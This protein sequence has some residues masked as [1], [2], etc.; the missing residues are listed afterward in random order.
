ML[1][2]IYDRLGDDLRRTTGHDMTLV[3]DPEVDGLVAVAI[4]GEALGGVSVPAKGDDGEAFLAELVDRLQEQF[5][6]RFVGGGWPTCPEHGTHPL[7]PVVVG[8]VAHWCCP[9]SGVVAAPIGGLDHPA[10][11]A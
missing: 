3:A 2:G 4:D 10:A 8:G 1:R 7:R 11:H 6:D 9:S 5:L